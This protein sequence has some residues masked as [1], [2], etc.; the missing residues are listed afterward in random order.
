MK[1]QAQERFDDHYIEKHSFLVEYPYKKK[2]ET[3]FLGDSLTRRWEDHLNLWNTFFDNETYLNMGVGGD[4]LEN[5]FW[6]IQNGEID[7]LNPKVAVVL[8]GTNNITQN[9][10]TYIASGIIEISNYLR[11]T[12][13]STDIVVLG[14]YPRLHD[15]NGNECSG[16]IHAINEILKEECS[17]NNFGYEYFGN[18]LLTREGKIDMR[19]MPDGL[20]LNELGYQRIGPILK[21][22][23]KKY[24]SI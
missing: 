16:K 13:T 8:A 3:I 11:S 9:S 10:I 15:E 2:I 7:G 24:S 18:E 4:T 1:L 23:I 12:L 14:L 17:K 5:I 22:I 21:A 20:H 6:R 19:I